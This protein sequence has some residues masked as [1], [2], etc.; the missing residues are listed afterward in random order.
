MRKFAVI[1]AGGKGL[2]MNSEIPKQFLP[3]NGKPVVFHTIDVFMQSFPDINIILVLPESQ[4]PL[5][6]NLCKI[7]HASY[8]VEIVVGGITRYLSVY[9]GLQTIP[10]NEESI[11]AIHDGVRPLVSTDIIKKAFSQVQ[12]KT[13]IIPVVKL[14][15]S[16]ISISNNKAIDR[17]LYRIVQTPQVFFVDTIKESYEFC[18]VLDTTGE[19]F[20][21]DASVYQK[22][23]YSIDIIDG[24]YHNLKITTTEDIIIAESLM[25]NTNG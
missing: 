20:T 21:D 1:V 22:A 2:R 16:L 24:S 12:Y 7:H 10:S 5:W 15:D 18:K 4:I 11:V 8:S 3:L 6:K 25:K 23:G 13:G 17:E 19:I 9:N 14:K